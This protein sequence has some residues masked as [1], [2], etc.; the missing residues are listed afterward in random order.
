MQINERLSIPRNEIQFSFARSGGPGG[1]NV[2][3]VETKAVLRWRPAESQALPEAVRERLLTSLR[4]RLTQEG[5]LVIACDRRRHRGRNM[6]ECLSRL[7][8]LVDSAVEPP[9]RRVATKPSRA[10]RD[11]R[12]DKKREVAARKRSRRPP[13]IDD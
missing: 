6:A 13:S 12:L 1:Q 11:R 8:E 10:S 9:K 5:D 3:K 4:N 7:R 2:N